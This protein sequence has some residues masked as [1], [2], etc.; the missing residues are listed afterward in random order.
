MAETTESLHR[1]F[2]LKPDAKVLTG[3]VGDLPEGVSKDVDYEPHPEKSIPLSQ[4]HQAIVQHILNLYGGSASEE[5]MQGT[6]AHLTCHIRP[7]SQLIPSSVRRESHL[8]R[9]LFVL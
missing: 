4:E 8:R 2:E 7:L 3:H 1:N 9:P 6:P 5:D